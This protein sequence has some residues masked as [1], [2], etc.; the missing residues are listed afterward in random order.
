VL[1]PAFSEALAMHAELLDQS[2]T[3]RAL[4]RIDQVEAR[5]WNELAGAEQPFLRHE[6]LSALEHQRCVG[7]DTGWQPRHLVV[8]DSC[9]RLT[10]AMPLYVKQHS[11]GEFVFDWSWA[12]AYR[13]HGLA[14]YPKLV[15]AVPFTPVSGARVLTAPDVDRRTVMTRLLGAARDLAEDHGCSSLHLL[16]PRSDELDLAGALGWLPRSDCRFLWRNYQYESFDQFLGTMTAAKRKKVKRERQRVLDAGIRFES[17]KGGE[18]DPDLWQTIYQL[19]ASTF[20]KRGQLPYCTREF[21]EELGRVLPENLLLILAT[22]NGR[23]VAVALFLEDRQALYGRYWGCDG[24]YHS[25]HFET[26][27][28]QGIERCI[29]NGLARFDPGAQGEHKLARGFEPTLSSSAHYIRD[30]RFAAAIARYLERERAAIDAYVADATA[31]LPF[32]APTTKL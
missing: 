11:W 7:G 15:C 21:F 25:L 23:I 27:Y 20:A 22:L 19:Y 6:F 5:S 14:Y 4:E 13:E 28:Y 32:R 17:R 3:V 9:G 18:V 26:C 12:E 2:V 10:G 31:H 30:P 16:F 8:Q 1:R 29:R 24:D